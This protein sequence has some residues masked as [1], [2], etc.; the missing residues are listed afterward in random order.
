MG[1]PNEG[2]D[3]GVMPWAEGRHST[4]GPPRHPLLGLLTER[5]IGLLGHRH[6]WKSRDTDS[7][8]MKWKRKWIAFVGWHRLDHFC[9]WESSIAHCWSI[10]CPL[11]FQWGQKW[12]LEAQKVMLAHLMKAY[13][14]STNGHVLFQA[15]GI[16][17]SMKQTKFPGPPG[18]MLLSST[19]P[20]RIWA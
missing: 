18:T 4:P 20:V 8:T 19:A 1:E 7:R 13:C 15:W 10:T 14:R 9:H 17:Q 11:D 6:Q 3:P 16:Y 5:H 12:R 2:L